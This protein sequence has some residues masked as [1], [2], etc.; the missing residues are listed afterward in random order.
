MRRIITSFM[1]FVSCLNFCAAQQVISSGGYTLSSGISVDWIL[2]GS[3]SDIQVFTPNIT[4]ILKEQEIESGISFKVYPMP[5]TDFINI[6]IT[7]VDSGQL[8]LE[9]FNS[10]GLKILKKAMSV[11]PVN[12]VSIK[13]LPSGSYFLRVFLVQKNRAC[14]KKIIKS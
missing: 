7:P 9:L 14:I 8:T 5:A 13:D 1:V 12:Q 4:D 11:Q 3:V 6:E 2:G 10:S